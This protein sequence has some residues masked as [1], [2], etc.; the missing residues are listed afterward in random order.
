MCGLCGSRIPADL[1]RQLRSAPDDD[2][3]KIGTDWA[4][5]QCQDLV[6]ND[7]A[8]IHF[9]TLNKSSATQS[10]FEALNA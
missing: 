6:D 5:R 8:G 7:V 2:V 1:L 3:K 9:Y 4:I 10:I